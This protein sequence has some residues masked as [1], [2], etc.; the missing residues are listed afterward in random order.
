MNDFSF[1]EQLEVLP[2]EELSRRALL[3]I[4]TDVENRDLEAVFNLLD[5]FGSLAQDE[6]KGF[7]RE[8]D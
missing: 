1:I 4:L 8:D 6:L 5:L 2:E 3:Q 7:L